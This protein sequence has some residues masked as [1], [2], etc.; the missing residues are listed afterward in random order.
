MLSQSAKEMVES[1]WKMEEKKIAEAGGKEA[2]DALSGAEQL[3]T[4]VNMMNALIWQLWRKAYYKMTDEEQWV[5]DL[6][7]WAGCYMHKELN[8]V[9]H[10]NLFMIKYWH[11]NNIPPPVL[12][13]NKDN[14]SAL[15]DLKDPSE[16]SNPAEL[17][18]L[19][20]ST[21]GGIKTTSIAGALFNHK[22]DKKGHQDLHWIYFQP[23]KKGA[24]IK[25][26]D[27]SNIQY[28]SHC[29]AAAELI[30]YHTHYINFLESIWDQRRTQNS[31]IWS[32]IFITAWKTGQHVP[33]W[34]LL[35]YMES[36]S[37]LHT[38]VIFTA[39]LISTF[40]PL[41]HFI[42]NSLH[43]SRNSLPIQMFSLWILLKDS[44]SW[45]SHNTNTHQQLS[46]FRSHRMI[47]LISVVSTKHFSQVLLNLGRTLQ[48]NSK[49]EAI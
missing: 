15:A 14:Q 29:D 32:S 18:A 16:T 39:R 25:F 38:S 31:T 6:F 37:A 8:S 10:A 28:Q 35:H 48:R 26:P 21:S 2:W 23:I 1:L 7:I 34:Q 17:Q 24:W 45:K 27:T 9:K 36:K 49:S 33:N 3:Q 41:D 4:D 44:T 11:N 20:T 42:K 5:M 47:C 46:Q 43:T 19:N 13:P 12:M 30:T 22:D 40:S